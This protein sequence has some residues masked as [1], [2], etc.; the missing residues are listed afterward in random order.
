MHVCV[1]MCV[2]DRSQHPMSLLRHCPLYSLKQSFSV[3]WNMPSRL[4]WP[5]IEPQGP[6]C[7]LLKYLHIMFK[8]I[9]YRP[10]AAVG[11]SQCLN[12]YNMLRLLMWVT[13]HF[14]CLSNVTKCPLVMGGFA[15]CK[16]L[17]RS[18]FPQ[19]RQQPAQPRPFPPGLSP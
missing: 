8:M 19:R 17:H 6:T 14:V 12:I 3:A 18:C 7:L 1:R 4:S 2:L 5:I 11:I 15:Q 16:L 10:Q 13:P 9:V